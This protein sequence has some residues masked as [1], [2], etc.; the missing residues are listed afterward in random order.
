[1]KTTEIAISIF[2]KSQSPYSQ[3]WKILYVPKCSGNS[4][5]FSQH[6]FLDTKILIFF[7]GTSVGLCDFFSDGKFDPEAISRGPCGP[8]ADR[9]GR[10][11]RPTA[12]RVSRTCQITW[13]P[14]AGRYCLPLRSHCIGHA[15]RKSVKFTF[16]RFCRTPCGRAITP[17]PLNSI[18]SC[19]GPHG[20][21]SYVI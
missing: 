17:T 11:G 6:N 2:R 10:P 19:I 16:F 14:V 5:T 9:R 7:N 3:K 12:Y 1:M 21:Q 15:T 20:L 18:G 8:I 4:D 13:M